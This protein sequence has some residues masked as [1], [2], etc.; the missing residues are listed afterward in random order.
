MGLSGGLA[1]RLGLGRS[2]VFDA[3]VTVH[4]LSQ[5]ERAYAAAR[6][7]GML[8]Y[9]CSLTRARALLR[10]RRQSAQSRS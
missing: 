2:T 9:A 8:S 7:L 10:S 6:G 4:E 3:T 1:E 5:G